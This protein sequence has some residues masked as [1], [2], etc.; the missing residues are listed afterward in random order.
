VNILIVEDSAVV[1]EALRW[2]LEAEDHTVTIINKN[3]RRLFNPQDPAWTDV[4]ALIC[5]LLM[6]EVKGADILR[7][8]KAS[9]PN[10]R[11]ICLTGVDGYGPL[12]DEARR[13]AHVVLQKP[14]DFAVI[15]DAIGPADA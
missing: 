10:V 7:A 14:S 4:D 15:L 11:R 8:S 6:P 5:D 3:M 12:I 2:V 13:N 1:A 9:H